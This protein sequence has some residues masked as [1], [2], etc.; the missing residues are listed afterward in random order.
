MF[1]YCLYG[2]W[3]LLKSKKY[4]IFCSSQK[5]QYDYSNNIT[6]DLYH[7]GHKMWVWFTV[8]PL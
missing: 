2:P 8:C 3:N 4:S 5:W 6:N 7:I 1:M